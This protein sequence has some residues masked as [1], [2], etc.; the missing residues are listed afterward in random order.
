MN[1]WQKSYK[2]KMSVYGYV[3][4]N[5]IINSNK[6]MDGC[7][8][9]WKLAFS[10]WILALSKSLQP[11]MRYSYLLLIFQIW[12]VFNFTYCYNFS[13]KLQ[14]YTKRVLSNI[15]EY[16]VQEIYCVKWKLITSIHIKFVPGY[17]DR[18]C[19]ES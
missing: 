15:S 11:L 3:S 16:C 19:T 7:F 9:V 17:P 4:G 14:V 18:M 10:R 2:F 12:I 1:L 6:R 13:K 5:G 8:L